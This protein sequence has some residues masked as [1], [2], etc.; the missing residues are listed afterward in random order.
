MAALAAGILI[1]VGIAGWRTPPMLSALEELRSGQLEKNTTGADA[2]TSSSN[3][4][5]QQIAAAKYFDDATPQ[6]ESKVPIGHEYALTEGTVELQFPAGATAIIEAP[7]VFLVVNDA[8]L[9]L[10]TGNCSV[11]APVGIDLSD[12]GYPENATF[13][14][15]FFQDAADDGNDFYPVFI[16]GLPSTP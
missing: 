9:L 8:N 4:R 14:G 16:A 3:V 6:L 12:L 5:L 15:L 7:A 2:T 11:H 13:E 10:K 1:G